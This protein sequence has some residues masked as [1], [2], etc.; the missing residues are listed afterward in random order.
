M[1]TRERF[2]DAVRPSPWSGH[3]VA[4]VRVRRNHLPCLRGPAMFFVT[5]SLLAVAHR[6]GYVATLRDRGR[7]LLLPLWLFAA[8]AFAA[9]AIAD[10]LTSAT[11]AC[12]GASHLV[13]GADRRPHGSQWEGGSMLLPLWYLRELLWTI[14]ASPVLLWAIRRVPA[15]VVAL[16]DRGVRHRPRGPSSTLADEKDDDAVDRWG[17]SFSIVLLVPWVLHRDGVCALPPRSVGDDRLVSGTAGAAWASPTGA[18]QCRQRLAPG[19]SLHR[20]RLV[21]RVHGGRAVDRRLAGA[22]SLATRFAPST[23]LDAIYLGIRPPLSWAIS[24]CGTSTCDAVRC[25]QREPSS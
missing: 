11:T 1:E 15:D 3:G 18:G 8:V 20:L 25:V 12:P 19:A 23:A 16:A 6:H 4:C 21:G 2:L 17:I 5:G 14:V 13:D 7:R 22:A 24:C 9:M 10:H